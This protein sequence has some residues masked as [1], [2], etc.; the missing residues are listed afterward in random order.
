MIRIISRTFLVYVSDCLD[1][2]RD[3]VQNSIQFKHIS[4]LENITYNILIQ[5][6]YC[7]HFIPLKGAKRVSGIWKEHKSLYTT[8]L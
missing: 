3:Y 1:E 4:N 2:T 7:T 5:A 8:E 6:L